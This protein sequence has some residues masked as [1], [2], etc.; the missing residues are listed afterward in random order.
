M[1]AKSFE[2]EEYWT[3]RYN[4]PQQRRGQ[5]FDWYIISFAKLADIIGPVLLQQFAVDDHDENN[6]TNALLRSSPV[7]LI[8]VG[9]GNSPFLTDAAAYVKAHCR[10]PLINEKVFI[11]TDFSEVAVLEQSQLLSRNTEVENM[12]VRFTHADARMTIGAE[13]SSVA[14]VMDKATL[15]AVDCSGNEENASAVVSTC[16]KSL[17]PGGYFF[18]LTC[19]PAAR[20]TETILRGITT[21]GVQCEHISTVSLNNDPVSPSHL[22]IFKR[23]AE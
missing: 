17:V 1:N 6:T 12:Q 8:D 13:E 20:R 7:A 3:E 19:R 9:C 14:V 21:S 5:L 10:S 2:S 11:G 4:D 15:D 16:V 22:L 18:S 23:S